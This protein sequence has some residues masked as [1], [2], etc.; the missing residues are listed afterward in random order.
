LKWKKKVIE[1]CNQNKITVDKERF[2][3]FL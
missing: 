1:L 3:R 2:L